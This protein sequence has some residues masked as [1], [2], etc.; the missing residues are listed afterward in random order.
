MNQDQF[1]SYLVEANV[2]D[3]NVQAYFDRLMMR[4]FES[5][6][7]L[8]SFVNATVFEE[9]KDVVIQLEFQRVPKDFH[10]DLSK[11]AG[12]R[13]VQI[14]NYDRNSIQLTGVQIRLSSEDIAPK[15]AEPGGDRPEMPFQTQRDIA[16]SSDMSVGL[17]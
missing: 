10:Q 5:P 16:G 12:A 9:G 7:L 3:S 2:D 17:R 11:I 15:K 6:P 4:L 13:E 8:A 1:L 14:V